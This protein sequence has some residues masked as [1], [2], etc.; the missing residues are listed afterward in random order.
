MF[1]SVEV[2]MEYHAFLGDLP[3]LAETEDLEATGVGQNG[4]RPA[5]VFV[6]AAEIANQFMAWAQVEV[7]G[8]R[9]NDFGVQILFQL[10]RGQ[11]FDGSL[12]ADGHENGGF[13]DSVRGMNPS[14]TGAGD[15]AFGLQFKM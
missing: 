13:D 4:A 9:Q 8:I 12:G 3:Y 15:G 10:R 6:Q 14:G 7:V 1:I 2:G 11:A 5:D